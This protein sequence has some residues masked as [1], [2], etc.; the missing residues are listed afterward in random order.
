M[1]PTPDASS[2]SDSRAVRHAIR[3][4]LAILSLTFS[5]RADEP[6]SPRP[7][8]DRGY[9]YQRDI[10]SEVPWSINIVRIS[11]TNTLLELHTT[12]AGGNSIGLATLSEHVARMSK[13]GGRAIAAINGDYFIRDGI[14]SG[15]PES[16]QILDGE[17][18]SAP[19]GKSSFWI[20]PA[21]NPHI[22]NVVSKLEVTWPDGST[23][24][25][26]LNEARPDDKPV[27]YTS[28]TRGSTHT[29]GGLEFVLERWDSSP[30]LPLVAGE[31]YDA[32]IAAVRDK[33]DGPIPPADGLVL[34]VPPGLTKRTANAAVGARIKISTA[35][36][37]DL[38]G[39]QTA[40]GGGPALLRGGKLAPFRSEAVRH[41]RSAVGWSRDFIYFVQVDGRQ[42]DLSV[43]MTLQELADKMQK[44]G[45][46]EAL[47]LDGGG[48]ST[49][50]MAG[51]IINSPCE[52]AERPMGNALVL[53]QKD[54]SS[55]TAGAAP[56]DK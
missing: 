12:L 8:S 49:L 56:G 55:G 16:L 51:Q 42:R 40:I 5:A 6:A 48:S 4:G 37:P 18:V 29:S 19:S 21:G 38:R 17:L 52:G 32:R 24:P 36:F 30:W 22:T 45:C 10:V 43:G 35:T 28:R 33:G 46:E 50:W 1:K 25:I 9:S 47:N 27:L 2:S 14:F 3:L 26:G 20:D 53:V 54:R 15:D 11:R 44:L 13:K 23:M 31:T 7:R 34:S 41:P 39:V